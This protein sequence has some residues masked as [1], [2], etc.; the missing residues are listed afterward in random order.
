MRHRP[1]CLLVLGRIGEFIPLDH[2][3]R[4]YDPDFVRRDLVC[5]T[6]SWF[7][8]VV[9]PFGVDRSVDP[10]GALADIFT[11]AGFGAASASSLWLLLEG[12]IPHCIL[13]F[14]I[15]VFFG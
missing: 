7:R 2:F 1:D 11:V 12:V 15:I 10:S 9:V 13:P 3:L 8:V 4:A 6:P 14:L 5:P